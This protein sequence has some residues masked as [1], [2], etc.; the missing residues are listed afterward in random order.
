MKSSPVNL[1]GSFFP[2]SSSSFLSL[3]FLFLRVRKREND[4]ANRLVIVRFALTTF[5]ARGP[6]FVCYLLHS[7]ASL[8]F[9]LYPHFN[10][11]FSHFPIFHSTFVFVFFVS[12]ASG[13][14]KSAISFFFSCNP[15]WV[16]VNFDETVKLGLFW[17]EIS[18]DL[19]ILELGFFVFGGVGIFDSFAQTEKLHWFWVEI[20]FFSLLFNGFWV[21]NITLIPS[22]HISPSL[23]LP[24]FSSF[25]FVFFVSLLLRVFFFLFIPCNLG[26]SLAWLI[27]TKLWNWVDF[28][29]KLASVDLRICTCVSSSWNG[30]FELKSSWV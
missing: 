8:A 21:E 3:T 29:M 27:L 22:S 17:N 1:E 25:F 14:F 19:R 7:P 16:L 15:W 26:V 4:W 28:E 13:F 2:S 24:L 30:Y 9:I 6:T 11:F 5:N 18:M 10:S 23:I 12:S 20:V